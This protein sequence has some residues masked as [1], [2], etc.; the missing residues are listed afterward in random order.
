MVEGGAARAFCVVLRYGG[1]AVDSDALERGSGSRLIIAASEGERVSGSEKLY[2]SYGNLRYIDLCLMAF[3]MLPGYGTAD[4]NTVIGI[5]VVSIPGR[6]SV[7]V[8]SWI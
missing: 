2:A 1:G 4:R 8:S 6:G 5:A 3:P 7:L